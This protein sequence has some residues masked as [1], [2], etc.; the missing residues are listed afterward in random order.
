MGRFLMGKRHVYKRQV[1]QVWYIRFLSILLYPVFYYTCLFSHRESAHKM[2]MSE[3]SREMYRTFWP[4][5][6]I[7]SARLDFRIKDAKYVLIDTICQNW[8]HKKTKFGEINLSKLE[9]DSITWW[10]MKD[11]YFDEISHHEFI[12]RYLFKKI[13]F[14]VYFLKKL[15]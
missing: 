2:W 8:K 11:G 3:E 9:I 1:K 12:Q 5:T 13:R 10:I 4:L 6:A 15:G 7:L 14:K